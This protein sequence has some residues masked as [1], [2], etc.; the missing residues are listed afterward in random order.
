MPNTIVIDGSVVA[1][2]RDLTINAIV[3]ATDDFKYDIESSKI[4][5]T[6]KNNVPSGRKTVRGET[7]GSATLQ[8]ATSATAVPDF[9]M[10]FTTTEGT[11]TIEKVGRTESKNGESKVP[12]TFCLNITGSIV[13]T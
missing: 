1:G 3:Y 6:D 4:V 9:G 12:I 8:L 5:R 11:F 7:T 10:Q 13:I 2:S